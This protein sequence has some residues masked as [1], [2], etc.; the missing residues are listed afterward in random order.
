MQLTSVTR[1]CHLP[2]ML[3]GI[4]LMLCT[5]AGAQ[6]KL[7]FCEEKKGCSIASTRL[8][9]AELE[10]MFR[11]PNLLLNADSTSFLVINGCQATLEKEKTP[12]QIHQSFGGQGTPG[13]KLNA[14]LRQY[15]SQ[16]GCIGCP[17]NTQ[18]ISFAVKS[19]EHSGSGYFFANLKSGEAYMPNASF[20]QFYAGTEGFGNMT[21]DAFFRDKKYISYVIDPEGKK[22][23]M[24]MAI[25]TDMKTID[26]QDLDNQEYFKNNF[27]A[28]GRKRPHLNTTLEEVEYSGQGEEGPLSFWL[29]PARTVCLPAGQFDALGF[30]NLGHLAIDGVTYLVCE[31][32]GPDFQ[33]RVT[34]VEEGSYQFNPAGYAPVGALKP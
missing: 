20:Q 7:L 18:R 31:I 17:N 11:Q 13:R 30:F 1:R 28:T 19:S 34:G 8:S 2:L 14:D 22:Y 9:E 15:L 5:S 10:A 29:T 6:R 26:G 4:A 12:Q 32:S 3:T 16:K 23:R 24:D 25:G 21:I 27:K 33:V